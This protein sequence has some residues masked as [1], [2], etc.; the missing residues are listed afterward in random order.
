MLSDSSLALFSRRQYAVPALLEAHCTDKHSLMSCLQCGACTVNC[1]LAQSESAT[2]PRHQMTLLQ[3]G[4]INQLLVDPNIWLCFNCQDCTASCPAHAEPGRIMAAIRQLAVESNLIP[5][6]FSRAI[7]HWRGTLALLL[8]AAA[9]LCAAIAAFGSVSS[10]AASV[11][12]RFANLL[13]DSV[14]NLM[15]GS[16]ACAMLSLTAVNAARVWKSFNQE[17]IART[18]P[19]RFLRALFSVLRQIAT[20]RQF[21]E[22]QEFPLSRAAHLAVFYG[23]MT[24][25]ALAG[26]AAALMVLGAPYPLPPLHPLKIA[27]NLAAAALIWGC[28][29]FCVKRWQM[30]VRHRG[31]SWFDWALLGQLLIVGTT[32]LLAECFRYAHLGL[33]AYAAYFLHL[34]FVFVLLAEAPYSKFAHIYFRTLALTAARYKAMAQAPQAGLVPGRIT[35]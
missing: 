19:A 33:L 23:F 3:F 2:F 25:T 5:R 29:Y 24:L 7:N 20:H 16:L 14:I 27:G 17:A 32:G 34:T 22:C 30:P 8:V 4:E 11:P 15:F 18:S 21:S 12:L 13:P 6:G 26:A 10:G 28:L 35:A 31:G 1:Q 9:I